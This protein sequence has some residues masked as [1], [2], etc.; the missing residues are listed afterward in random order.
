MLDFWEKIVVPLLSDIGFWLLSIL[1][2]PFLYFSF[3]YTPNVSVSEKFELQAGKSV[4]HAV[5]IAC[6]LTLSS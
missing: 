1:E 5:V 3:Y 6:S 4:Y 2:P